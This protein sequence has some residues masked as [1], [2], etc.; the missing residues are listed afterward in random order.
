M[1]KPIEIHSRVAARR[2]PFE[3]A[4]L[5]RVRQQRALKFGNVVESVASN[6]FRI[7][8]DDGTESCETTKVLKL[9]PTDAGALPRARALSTVPFTEP[10]QA[11]PCPSAPV[12]PGSVHGGVAPLAA[13]PAVRRAPVPNPKS[14]QLPVPPLLV[15]DHAPSPGVS[16]HVTLNI[17]VPWLV[18]LSKAAPGAGPDTWQ[19][20]TQMVEDFNHNRMMIM[21]VMGVWITF[22]EAMGAYQPRSTNTGGLPNISF[23]KRKPKPLGT[24]GKTACDCAT[25]VMIHFEIQEGRDAMKLKEHAPELVAVGKTG[26]HFIACVKTSHSMYRKAYL[27]DSLESHL[28]DKPAGSRMVLRPTAEGVGLM[29]IGTERVLADITNEPAPLP[30]GIMHL[31]NRPGNDNATKQA[32]CTMCRVDDDNVGWT[33]Y[34]CPNCDIARKRRKGVA[35]WTRHRRMTAQ[36][37]AVYG[38]N[39][40]AD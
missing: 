25:G 10:R 23:I 3:P 34:K 14:C 12:R 7:R 6:K 11:M 15:A 5:G 17:S 33:S 16:I 13:A 28:K 32:R 21:L 39:R 27:E 26:R 35:C 24:E 40:R 1:R 20:S 19:M 31:G 29:A 9:Q 38:V 22:D 36:Q 8:R 2:G 37:L 30:H 18:K 4:A